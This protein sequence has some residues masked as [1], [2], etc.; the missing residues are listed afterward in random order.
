[1]LNLTHNSIKWLK[2]QVDKALGLPIPDPKCLEPVLPLAP[3]ISCSS[4]F[5][6]FILP[7]D[8]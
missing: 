4:T 5:H 8:F 6:I 1:M 7:C 2:I 3:S